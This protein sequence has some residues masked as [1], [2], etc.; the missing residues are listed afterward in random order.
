[1]SELSGI[2]TKRQE[3]ASIVQQFICRAPKKNHEALV[4]LAKEF[5]DMFRNQG[6]MRIEYFQLSNTDDISDF[7]NM[8]KTVPST[9]SAEEEEIW[10]EQII[11]RDS[12][13]KDE[14][15]AKCMSDQNVDRL[16]KQFISLITPGSAIMGKFNRIIV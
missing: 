9:K 3:A 13:H 6:D 2:E 16:Y 11:F 1:M 10:M 5:T 4:Q 8:A 7:T 15:I 14:Y 12:K